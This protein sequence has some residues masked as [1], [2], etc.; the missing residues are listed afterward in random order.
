MNSST[1]PKK[2]STASWEEEMLKDF[3]ED[4]NKI[5]ESKQFGLL[6]ALIAAFAVLATL[7]YQKEHP[8]SQDATPTPVTQP[9]TP[10]SR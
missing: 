5:L 7:G 8:E 3:W 9:T 2:P 1:G 6:L 4:T 10:S